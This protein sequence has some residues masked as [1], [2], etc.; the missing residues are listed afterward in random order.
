MRLHFV[1]SVLPMG[2]GGEGEKGVGKGR[3]R[4]GKEGSGQGG[5]GRGGDYGA[6]AWGETGQEER[7]KA[8][9]KK[10]YCEEGENVIGC[11]YGEGSCQRRGRSVGRRREDFTGDEKRI[12]C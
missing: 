8:M 6:R 1:Q 7:E 10:K 9:W 5:L 2:W 11:K 3:V 12:Y 4:G